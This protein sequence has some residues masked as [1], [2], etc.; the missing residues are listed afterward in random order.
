MHG[1]EKYALYCK[2]YPIAIVWVHFFKYI[3]FSSK[4]TF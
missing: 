3:V 2:K 1:L 4:P